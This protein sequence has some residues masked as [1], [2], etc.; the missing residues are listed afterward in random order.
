[1]RRAVLL[2][3]V[4]AAVVPPTVR[5]QDAGAPDPELEDFRRMVRSDPFTR[6]GEDPIGIDARD[7]ELRTMRLPEPE[8]IVEPRIPPQQ[9]E[10][11][12]TVPGVRESAHG[13]DVELRGGLAIAREEMRFTSSARL[14][15]EVQVRLAVPEGAALVSLEVC[16]AAGC[17]SGLPD[18]AAGALS[19]YD[20]AARARTAA[21]RPLPIAHARTARDDRGSAIVV[22]AAPVGGSSGEQPSGE[23]IVRVGWAAR[24][25]V[26]G[27]RTEIVVP[28]RGNDARVA[29]IAVRVS[30]IDVVAPEID[31]V[32]AER[33]EI[34]RAS[35]PI[36]IR[37]ATPVTAGTRATAE[38]VPCAASGAASGGAASGRCARVRVVAARP[39]IA[40]GDVV[41]AIDASPSTSATARGRIAPAVRA[42]LAMLPAAS[43][44]RVVAF[45]AR[46]EELGRGWASPT[47]IDRDAIDLAV[48]RALG[49]ATRFEALWS[50]IEG[51]VRAGARVV[52]VGDGGWTE[53]AE[54]RAAVAAARARRIWLASIDVA[55]RPTT[56]A[57][58]RA[59]EGSGFLAIDAGAA[60]EQAAARRDDGPLVARI[61]A[62]I[63]P[64]AV[65]DVSLRN[66][67]ARIAL[68]ALRAGE[69]V[70]W[71]GPLGGALAVS[72]DGSTSRG[73]AAS[74]ELAPALSA[75]AGGGAVALAAVDPRDLARRDAGSCHA[76]GPYATESAVV[77]RTVALAL[78]HTRR[79]DPPAPESAAA[80]AARRS[81]LP[82]RVLLATLRRRVIPAARGCFRDDRRGRADYQERAELRLE[83]A[84]R[85]IVGS[86]VEGE[87]EPE[88]RAC[89]SSALDN[90][91]VPGFDGSVIVRWPLYTRAIAPPP[92]I[93]LAPG[94]AADVD[95]MFPPEPE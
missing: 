57:L 75:L 67:G 92:V 70:R 51:D 41:I 63:A 52:I 25:V 76:Q 4:L 53:S 85:E 73:T 24:T 61:T 30:A 13:L 22:R 64:V 23:L 8:E 31:T 14:P 27:G 33:A 20:D 37:A 6:D 11:L 35:S 71:E 44:V 79:C 34:R 66:G 43:R 84:D 68:G 94:L 86:S 60:A 3:L 10:V 21:P 72:L 62:A 81:G 77:A 82:A 26:H 78:A 50:A 42:L 1:M 40:P 87:V 38:I 5:G 89:L 47:E 95:R 12:T 91:E 69:E 18:R 49:S 88:L 56:P 54:S 93:E 7:D 17:R 59:F 9:G 55:D 15:A 29:E 39:V 74:A 28:A 2:L 16:H 32:P 58:R 45:A 48:D 83:L 80:P 36:T 90:L 19:A 46:A 65:R